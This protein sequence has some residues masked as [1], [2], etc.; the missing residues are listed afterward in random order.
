MVKIFS[1]S[2]ICMLY[3]SFSPYFAWAFS[4]FLSLEGGHKVLTPLW[5]NLVRFQHVISLTDWLMKFQ[6]WRGMT[7]QWRHKQ[8]SWIL[9]P[10][11]WIPSLQSYNWQWGHRKIYQFVLRNILNQ[12][13]HKKVKDFLVLT[14]E[15][16]KTEKRLEKRQRIVKILSWVDSCY[17]NVNHHRYVIDTGNFSLINFRKSHEIWWLFVLPFK[18]N[19]S[20]QRRYNVPPATP[21]IGLIGLK[22]SRGLWPSP[23]ISEL[24][25]LQEAMSSWSVEDI[26]KKCSVA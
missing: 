4:E 20:L 26:T 6:L 17:G 22:T 14:N 18:S 5:W 2:G 3:S 16:G 10:S 13:K 11:S 19:N 23:I 21:P 9:R 25:Q 12:N 7:S 1:I 24:N 8:P 15:G